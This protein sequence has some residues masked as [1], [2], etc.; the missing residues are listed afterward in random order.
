MSQSHLRKL[1]IFWIEDAGHDDLAEVA[2]EQY[3][4]TLKAFQQL[5]EQ[6]KL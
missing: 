2:G 6:Q 4:M 3:Q 5:I 1:L